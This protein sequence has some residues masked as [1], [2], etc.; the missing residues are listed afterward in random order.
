MDTPHPFARAGDVRVRRERQYAHSLVHA[1]VCSRRRKRE[2]LAKREARSLPR[3][4]EAAAHL[5]REYACDLPP[6]IRREA[7][8]RAVGYGVRLC[9]LAGPDS[10]VYGRREPSR[11][12]LCLLCQGHPQA[13]AHTRTRHAPHFDSHTR[14]T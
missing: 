2:H 11:T 9:E 10:G 12:C 3:R 5:A 6:R 7:V 14:T 4:R 1:H 8:L 13:T